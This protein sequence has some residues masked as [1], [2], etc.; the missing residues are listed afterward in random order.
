[1]TESVT[2]GIAQLESVI[3]ELSQPAPRGITKEAVARANRVVTERRRKLEEYLED[4]QHN[5]EDVLA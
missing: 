3:Q 4:R 1:M 5:N 2:Q